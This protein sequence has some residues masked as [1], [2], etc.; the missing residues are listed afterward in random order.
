M[1]NKVGEES[2]K[3]E[4]AA[5]LYNRLCVRVLQRRGTVSRL[6]RFVIDRS[7]HADIEDR[8]DEMKAECDNTISKTFAES[9]TIEAEIRASRDWERNSQPQ[10]PGPHQDAVDEYEAYLLQESTN[11]TSAHM[12]PK[13][14]IKLHEQ[15]CK[16]LPESLVETVG[17][18]QPTSVPAERLF[19]RARHSRK[20]CQE[21]LAD[22]RFADYLFLKSYYSE[23]MPW[24]DF[25]AEHGMMPEID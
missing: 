13:Q 21:R 15:G 22:D 8:L 24:V 7:M 10:C 5:K 2:L 17:I 11:F 23:N 18:I 25:T 16:V 3:S 20:Y 9:N 14:I 6:A 4:F 19:S 12:A 1:L